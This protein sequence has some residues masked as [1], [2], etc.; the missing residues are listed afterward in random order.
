MPKPIRMS[1][2][3]FEKLVSQQKGEWSLP[4]MTRR[5]KAMEK[6]IDGIEAW[7]AKIATKV[8]HDID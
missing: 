6:R 7:L 2:K 4:Y 3:N 1:K 8:L 5:F